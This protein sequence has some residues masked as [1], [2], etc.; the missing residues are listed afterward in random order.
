MVRIILILL[1][2][3]F[4]AT[5]ASAREIPNVVLHYANLFAQRQTAQEQL[6]QGRT[7]RDEY[8]RYFFDGFT[9]PSG[10]VFT[11]SAL[12]QDAYTRGQTYWRDHPAERA[13]IFSEYGYVAIEREGVWSRGF[14]KSAFE[15]ADADGDRWWMRPL[16]DGPWKE[17]GLDQG[18]RV[19]I[20]GYLSPKGHYGHLGA[21]EHQVLVTSA[22]PV[23]F[24]PK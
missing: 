9:H 15:P 14:E 11:K 20:A 18:G 12:I 8:A 7:A 13:K 17:V 22:V 3:S 6:P 4:L 24:G 16:G 5:K 23:D 10:E 21:Y 2:T 19:R 1:V